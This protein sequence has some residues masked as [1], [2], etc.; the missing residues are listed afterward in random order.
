MLEKIN[1][2]E[3]SNLSIPLG[4]AFTPSKQFI[5]PQFEF[6]VTKMVKIRK[7]NQ[8]YLKFD[9]EMTVEYIL[10]VGTTTGEILTFLIYSKNSKYEIKLFT[11][12]DIS[13]HRI[14]SITESYDYICI[15][16]V[17]SLSNDGSISIISVLDQIVLAHYP[18]QYV[19]NSFGLCCTY[20]SEFSY[21]AIEDSY[22]IA[23]SKI[24]LS[25][26]HI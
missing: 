14:N 7:E 24:N 22:R 16:T 2:T 3:L 18:A 6:T 13:K 20:I 15:Q 19:F 4:I 10:F 12:I 25:L 8:H 21:L 1:P 9:P 26:I 11:I 23:Y 5:S 17:T